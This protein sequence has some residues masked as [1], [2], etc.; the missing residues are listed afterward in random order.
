MVNMVLLKYTK[1][2]QSDLR[3]EIW[4]AIIENLGVKTD[5]KISKIISYYIEIYSINFASLLNDYF[6]KI[7]TIKIRIV[8]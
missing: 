6:I 3:Y 7:S 2:I 4:N 1:K 5:V 8:L